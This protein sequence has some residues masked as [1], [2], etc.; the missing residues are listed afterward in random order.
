MSKKLETEDVEGERP[1]DEFAPGAGPDG[2]PVMLTPDEAAKLVGERDAEEE[3]FGAVVGDPE[4]GDD[5]SDLEDDDS[6]VLDAIAK[7]E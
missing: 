5:L 4:E 7:A 2:K 3:A 1:A 6:A